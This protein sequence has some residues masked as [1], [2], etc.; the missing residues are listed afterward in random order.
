MDF[1]FYETTQTNMNSSKLTAYRINLILALR[2]SATKSGLLSRRHQGLCC[3]KNKFDNFAYTNGNQWLFPELYSITRFQK[4][5][6]CFRSCSWPVIPKK[7]RDSIA[8]YMLKCLV[9]P[10]CNCTIS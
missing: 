6:L 2:V 8:F 4:Q 5:N 3:I 7:E 10:A 1:D 9:V